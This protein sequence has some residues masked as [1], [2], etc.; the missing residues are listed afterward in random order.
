MPSLQEV[1]N[2]AYL[3]AWFEKGLGVDLKGCVEPEMRP[4][5]SPDASN[6]QNTSTQAYPIPCVV[7]QSLG[8]YIIPEKEAEMSKES[9]GKIGLPGGKQFT[10]TEQDMHGGT[11][12]H[13][14]HW[15]KKATWE[16][17]S[18]GGGVQNTSSGHSNPSLI[19]DKL[20]KGHP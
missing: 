2:E 3:D 10:T 4:V 12:T 14:W 11:I 7:Q 19:V 6:Q 16:M 20:L 13:F 18:G 8:T 5:S 9:L 1:S 17:N 15:D